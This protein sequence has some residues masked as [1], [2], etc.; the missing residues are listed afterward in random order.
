MQGAGCWILDKSYLSLVN[1]HWENKK[2]ETWNLE[3][4]TWNLESGTLNFKLFPPFQK[5][6]AE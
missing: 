5:T 3:P 1:S 4:G 2:L 6:F